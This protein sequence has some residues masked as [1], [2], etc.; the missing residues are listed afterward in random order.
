MLLS[1]DT[2]SISLD[3]GRLTAAE[4]RITGERFAV[5]DGAEYAVFDGT[6]T[7]DGIDVK[8]TA[9]GGY[10]EKTVTFTAPAEPGAGSP[11]GAEDCGGAGGQRASSGPGL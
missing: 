1:N 7:S 2:M 3:A 8:W 10:F 4:N 11:G 9:R 6:V 5:G